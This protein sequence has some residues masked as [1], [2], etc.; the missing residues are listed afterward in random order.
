ME[1]A[2]LTDME[3]C[4]LCPRN[5]RADRRSGKAGYCGQTE[6]IRIARAALH[7]W[8]E[9]CISGRS[10]S[11]TV[12]FSGCNLRCVFCQNRDIAIGQRGQVISG[13]RLAEIF[14][15][16]QE[17]NANNINLVTPAHYAPQIV[18]ALE[19]AKLQG[20]RI[21]VVYNTSSYEKAETLCMLE[22]LVDIWLPDMKYSSAEL[23][24]KYSNAPDY[25]EV[26][27]TAIAEMVR[28]VKEPVFCTAD[29]HLLNSVQ[30]NAA[31]EESEDA[32]FLMKKG[33]IVRHL[34]LPGQEEDSKA[35]LWELY[36]TFGDEIY[37]SI[38]NQ[39]T[40]MCWFEKY[41]ELNR[42]VSEEEY[43]RVLDFAV[44]IGM[45]NVF[46]QDGET[47]EESFIPAFDGEGVLAVQES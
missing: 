26:A 15:E 28:Q 25:F 20:L 36:Q 21:P 27:M 6:E 40:P 41:P 1:L 19:R 22:G 4:I 30:M 39:Y 42:K 24:R 18:G 35:V 34:V 46:I 47:A 3:N 16:L 45:E 10:G 37:V 31:C 14:L 38:M 32:D 44:E 9:P 7:F 11:G 5:C 12:F 8:E 17:Q 43:D 33:V 29:G 23:A 2:R 13:E